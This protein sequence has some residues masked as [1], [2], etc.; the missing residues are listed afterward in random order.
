MYLI[1]RKNLND[2]NFRISQKQEIY[3]MLS[4]VYKNNIQGKYIFFKHITRIQEIFVRI[5]L[6]H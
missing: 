2:D 6:L 3:Q 5:N 1:F 4:I